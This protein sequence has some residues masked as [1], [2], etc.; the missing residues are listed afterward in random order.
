[1]KRYKLFKLLIPVIVLGLLGQSCSNFED[2]NTNPAAST[3]ADPKSLIAKVTIH[4]SGD[5][6][7]IWRSTAG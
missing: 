2:L 7:T 1:M 3:K 5:R 4:Y 6:E